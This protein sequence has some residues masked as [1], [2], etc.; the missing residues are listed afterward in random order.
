MDKRLKQLYQSVILQHNKSPYH[1]QINEAAPHQI[2]AYNPLCGDQFKLYLDIQEGKVH[3]ASFHGFGCAISKSATSVLIKQIEGKSI[4]EIQELCATYRTVTDPAIKEIT[5]KEEELL[6][7]EAAKA[8]PERLKC[9][10]LSWEALE[11]FFSE[12]REV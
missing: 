6:A 7:F 1:Y 9:A 3:Q 12:K 5:T 4:A 8:F 10:T 2:E 11:A